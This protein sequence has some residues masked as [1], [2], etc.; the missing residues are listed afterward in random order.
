MDPVA[1]A[2]IMILGCLLLCCGRGVRGGEAETKQP[3]APVILLPRTGQALSYAKGDDGDLKKGVAGDWRMP[4][5]N[6]LR[7]LMHWGF[8]RPP[9]SN[10]AGTE[11]WKEGD[12]FINMDLDKIKDHFGGGK[13]WSSTSDGG[14]ARWVSIVDGFCTGRGKTEEEHVWP[15]RDGR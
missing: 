11:K 3:P 14:T 6:E 4:N 9:L 1:F 15:V 8:N 2:R 7:S 5:I 13:Y 12:P 10:A